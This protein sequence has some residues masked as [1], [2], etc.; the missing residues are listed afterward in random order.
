MVET[1]AS[2]A[3]GVACEVT[4]QEAIFIHSMFRNTSCDYSNVTI[5]SVLNPN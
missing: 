4:E 1:P 2:D 5:G 3:A